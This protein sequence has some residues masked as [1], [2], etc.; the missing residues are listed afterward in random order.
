METLRTG[1]TWAPRAGPPG[2]RGWRWVGDRPLCSFSGNLVSTYCML[3][4]VWGLWRPPGHGFCEEA[5]GLVRK[6]ESQSHGG[7]SLSARDTSEVLGE[8]ACKV[9]RAQVLLGDSRAGW[10]AAPPAPHGL[11]CPPG[12]RAC[13]PD[14]LQLRGGLRTQEGLPRGSWVSSPRGFW[15]GAGASSRG[16]GGRE[17]VPPDLSRPLSLEAQMAEGW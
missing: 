16:H 6:T 10:M 9:W 17:L 11:L 13:R 1:E 3:A 12:P 7:E 15:A 4:L 2:P 5:P 14:S 8:V